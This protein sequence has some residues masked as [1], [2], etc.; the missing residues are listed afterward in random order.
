M[1]RR[2]EPAPVSEDQNLTLPG[3]DADGPAAGTPSD[4]YAPRLDGLDGARVAYIDW[5]KPNG[6]ALYESL[7]RRFRG[8]FGAD[9]FAYFGKPS[10][11]SPVPGR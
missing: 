5:G 2:A 8:E 9:E 4:P 10:P 3:A 11:S 7:G 1:C 6:E